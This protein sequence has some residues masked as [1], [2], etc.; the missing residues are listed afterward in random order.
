MIVEASDIVTPLTVD[1][2]DCSLVF[3][4]AVS[5]ARAS[6]IGSSDL[7]SKRPK[8]SGDSSVH[9]KTEISLF[10][11]S[12]IVSP[13]ERLM[14]TEAEAQRFS[15]DPGRPLIS[16]VSM[17]TCNEQYHQASRKFNTALVISIRMIIVSMLTESVVCTTRTWAS[18]QISL[19]FC[20][21]S[22]ETSCGND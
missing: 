12:R 22:S 15:S 8:S 11:T 19:T 3:D 16:P 18:S 21:K 13:G 20:I 9:A 14:T 10:F 2:P 6:F 5:T 1:P 17:R 7:S 4:K